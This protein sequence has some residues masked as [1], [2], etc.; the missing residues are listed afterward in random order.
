MIKP[1]YSTNGPDNL[2]LDSIVDTFGFGAEPVRCTIVSRQ[3]PDGT[4]GVQSLKGAY[5]RIHAD[6]IVRVVD[7]STRNDP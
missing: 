6:D 2:P 3:R 5:N 4:Y 7:V 1:Q